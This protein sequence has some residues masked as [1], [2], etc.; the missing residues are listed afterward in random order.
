MKIRILLLVSL[1]LL[2]GWWWLGR[3]DKSFRMIFCDVGQGDAA[4]II[5]GNF[6]MMIDVGPENRKILNCLEDNLPFSDRLLELVLITHWDADHAGGLKDI[7]KYYKIEKLFSG[8]KPSADFEQINYTGNLKAGDLIKYELMTFEILSVQG[9]EGKGLD[10]ENGNSM[11]G[12]LSYKDYK[13]FMMADAPKEV[14]QRLVWRRKLE[15]RDQIP[16]TRILKVSHHGSE[17]GTSEELL[18]EI[19]PETAIISVGKGNMFG[20]PAAAVLGKLFKREIRVL[21][22]DEVGEIRFVLD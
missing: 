13:F 5:S 2:G 4:L 6:Q 21:R 17:T 14:E 15:T 20:H 3:P 18:D 8:V 10:T 1:V 12:I 19:K 9:I 11:A 22:T 7:L 16:E